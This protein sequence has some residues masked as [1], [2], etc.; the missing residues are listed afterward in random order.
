M[1]TTAPSNVAAIAAEKPQ[2]TG[3]GLYARFALAGGL[4]CQATHT[5]LVPMD[6]VKTRLQTNPGMYTGALHATRS[7][8]QQQGA[9]ALLLGMTPTFVGY[10]LQ[11]AG[12]FGLNEWFKDM[13]MERLTSEQQNMYR[14]PVYLTCSALAESIASVFLSPWEA[15]RIRMVASG[16]VRASSASVMRGIVAAEGMRGLYKGLGPLLAKQVPYTMT[17]LTVFSATLDTFYERVLPAL[18]PHAHTKDSLS[19]SQQLAVSVG[20]GAIAGVASAITS[21]PA[22]TVLS[23]INMQS[24]GAGQASVVECVKQLGFRGVWAGLG[25]RCAMVSLLSA[26]M[27]LIYDSVKLACGLPTSGK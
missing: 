20:A 14:I 22:D 11:G 21:H 18:R 4:C 26:G 2:P 23:R 6:V 27:F 19:T 13:T 5:V 8:V 9:R 15:V 25:T 3:F 12:K 17:Q 10:M 24:N 7:I 16:D 1:S